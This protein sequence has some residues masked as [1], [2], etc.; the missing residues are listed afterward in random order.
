MS[1]GIRFFNIAIRQACDRLLLGKARH[2]GHFPC[3]YKAA[4]A[5]TLIEILVVI[6]IIAILIALLLPAVQA[7]ARGGTAAFSAATISS[8]WAWPSRLITTRT[9]F[10]PS[11]GPGSTPP[12]VRRTRTDGPG[13]LARCRTSSKPT[14][15]MRSTARSHST[16]FRMPRQSCLSFRHSS[17][18]AISPGSRSRIARCRA[19]SRISLPTGVTRITSKARPGFQRRWPEPV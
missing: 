14:P 10:C 3:V 11:A 5:S 9:T 1:S 4:K 8:R 7:G 19:S 18:R 13:R 16:T 6:S 12:I 17:V 2:R 15:S